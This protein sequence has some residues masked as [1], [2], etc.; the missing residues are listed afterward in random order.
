MVI[1]VKKVRAASHHCSS[2]GTASARQHATAWAG[3]SKR[4]GGSSRTHSFPTSSAAPLSTHRT[5]KKTMQHFT[6]ICPNH[7][8]SSKLDSTQSLEVPGFQHINSPASVYRYRA[9]ER[10]MDRHTE[11]IS[12]TQVLTTRQP[13]R[14]Y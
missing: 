10:E 1:P 2:T 14:L 12:E 3:V 6:T 5:C 11:N 8:N 4:R 9:G 13:Y 7:P